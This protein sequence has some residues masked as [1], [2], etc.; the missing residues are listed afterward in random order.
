MG[1]GAPKACPPT[2]DNGRPF[3]WA[4]AVAD[5]STGYE[6][7]KLSNNWSASRRRRRSPP[8]KP[9]TAEGGGGLRS[10]SLSTLADLSLRNREHM[11]GNRLLPAKH[12]LT[13]SY[14]IHNNYLGC[15]GGLL[16]QRRP[17]SPLLRDLRC[18][19]CTIRLA[20]L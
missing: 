18:D 13:L 12:V 3:E 8:S 9:P 10:Y 5:Y 6:L 7:H 2:T 20:A 11:G 15:G 14:R 16:A 17:V 19:S 4:A 1:P